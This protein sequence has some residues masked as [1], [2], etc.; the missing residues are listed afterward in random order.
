MLTEQK[1]DSVSIVLSTSSDTISIDT[2]S[3]DAQSF[4]S[5]SSKS[6]STINLTFSPVEETSSL[7]PTKKKKRN[8]L[9]SIK[10]KVSNPTD[11]LR[12]VKRDIKSFISKDKQRKRENY[13][14]EY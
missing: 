5:I 11:I 14:P 8:I 6:P 1:T 4:K 12:N 7:T 10:D 2:L 13:F 9:I 3:L